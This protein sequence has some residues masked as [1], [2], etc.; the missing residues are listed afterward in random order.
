[1]DVRY[2]PGGAFPGGGYSPVRG[3]TASLFTSRPALFCT[4]SSSYL[5]VR[6]GNEYHM[7]HK[8]QRSTAQEGCYCDLCCATYC[9]LFRSQS[10]SSKHIHELTCATPAKQIELD[11][12]LASLIFCNHLMISPLDVQSHRKVRGPCTT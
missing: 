7:Q 8:C 10:H 3:L 2:K 4:L 11:H 6:R 12:I 1:M 9:T 5:S